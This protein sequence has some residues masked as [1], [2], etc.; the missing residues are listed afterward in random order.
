MKLFIPAFLLSI[1]ALEAPTSVQGHGFVIIPTSRNHYAHVHG[2]S[3]G[4]APAVP[5]AEYCEHCLNANRGVCGISEQG[6]DNGP[7]LKKMVQ[8][9]R[10]GT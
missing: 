2:T 9:W 7:I 8:P 1:V 10:W 4:Q 6:I 3:Y 5:P